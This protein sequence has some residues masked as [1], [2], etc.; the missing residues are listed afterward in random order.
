[1]SIHLGG[2]G[3]GHI[4]RVQGGLLPMDVFLIAGQSN[5]E[6]RGTTGDASPSTV[7]YYID[8]SS[9]VYPLADPVGGAL[10][11]SMWPAFAN[12]WLAQTGRRAAFVEGATGGTALLAAADTGSGNWS[13]TGTQRASAVSTFNT[14]IAAI[15]GAPDHTLGNVYVVWVQGEADAQ[16]V[17]GSTVTGALYK[18]ALIDLCDYFDANITGGIEE[19]LVVRSGR[20]NDLLFPAGFAEIRA[21][22][23]AACAD[24]A[25]LR[26]IYRGAYSFNYAGQRLMEDTLHWNRTAL[27]R[28]GKAGA[29][30]A[31][32]LTDDP[33]VPTAPTLLA[34][35]A[36][37]DTNVTAATSSTNSHTTASGTKMLVVAFAV[38]RTTQ[39]NTNSL[40]GVTFNGVAMTRMNAPS[41]GTTAA[42]NTSP[43]GRTDIAIFGLTE[44]EY[45]GTLSGVTANIVA[46]STLSS[47]INSVAAFNLDA[48][49][50]CDVSYANTL[51]GG[52]TG[53][54]LTF[55]VTT[56]QPGLLIGVASSV[57]SSA[58]ALTWTLAGLTEIGDGGAS[59]GTKSGQVAFGHESVGEVSGATITATASGTMDSGA[60]L[61][62]S[63]RK[64]LDGE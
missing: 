62:A 33:A 25:K 64:K 23:D 20:R 39:S 47:Q 53:T 37:V 58:S 29:R 56:G 50:I 30:A 31:A 10:N 61:V 19:M 21:A 18:Q 60:F 7:Q 2:R 49:A 48:E 35:Q 38:A 16:A 11:A 22:Q 26:M 5:A 13:P 36:F 3:P 8:G 34:S 15:D 45:G 9:I 27:N 59:D 17:N 40:T 46:T 52:T 55:D 14:A 44:T 28:A 24:H 32:T 6:G 1:M 12:E 41:P 51:T 43:A 42:A 4:A 57:A 63:F 54:T